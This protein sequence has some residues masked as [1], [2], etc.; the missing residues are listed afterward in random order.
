MK[1]KSGTIGFTNWF[2]LMFQCVDQSEKSKSQIQ[3]LWLV[4]TMKHEKKPV[5]EYEIQ[6]RNDRIH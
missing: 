5:S 3:V 2:F 1:Y 4:D 6:V